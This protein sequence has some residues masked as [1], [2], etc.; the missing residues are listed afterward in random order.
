[1][2]D[3]NPEAGGYVMYRSNILI[4]AILL[5]DVLHNGSS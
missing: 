4:Y 3:K 2:N 5:I 1:M